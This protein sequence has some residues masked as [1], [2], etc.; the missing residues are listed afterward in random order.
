[1][2][3]TEDQRNA[4]KAAARQSFE[5]GAVVRLFGSRLDDHRQGGDID[6]LIETQMTDPAHIVRAHTQFLSHVYSSLGEQK[7]DVVIDY[8]NRQ[9]HSPIYAHARETGV[10]L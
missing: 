3:L 4:L 5:P 1:M 9:T 2:R 7:I 8:P 10:P 6:L